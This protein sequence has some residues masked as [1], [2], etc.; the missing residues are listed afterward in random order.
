MLH[1]REFSFFFQGD[2]RELYGNFISSGLCRGVKS[3]DYVLK[4]WNKIRCSVIF[5]LHSPFPG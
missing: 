4:S 5:D 1:V 3:Q 2:V